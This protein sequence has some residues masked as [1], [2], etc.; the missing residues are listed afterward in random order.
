MSFVVDYP[1]PDE[2]EYGVYNVSNALVELD[3]EVTI[4]AALKGSQ[5]LPTSHLIRHWEYGTGSI[6][7]WVPHF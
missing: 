1:F 3:H 6:R 7:R 5:V 4:F 2:L